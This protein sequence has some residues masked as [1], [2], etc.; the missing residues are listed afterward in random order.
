MARA[1]KKKKKRFTVILWDFSRR[2]EQKD[3]LQIKYVLIQNAEG[4]DSKGL[5]IEL[6]T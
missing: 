4:T 1:K 5:H 3:S 6:V 2:N